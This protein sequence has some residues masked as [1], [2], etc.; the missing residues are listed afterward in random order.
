MDRVLASPG[1]PLDTATRGFMEQRFGHDFSQVRTHADSEGGESARRLNALAYTVGN[2]IAFAPGQY[3]PNTSGGR[4]LLAHELTH[5]VQQ[6]G[7][8]ELV[9]QRQPA[10]TVG[11][12]DTAVSVFAYAKGA[13]VGL[14]D[15]FPDALFGFAPNNISNWVHGVT[16]QNLTITEATADRVRAAFSGPVKQMIPGGGSGPDIPDVS[17]GIDRIGA[18]RFQI[19][20]DSGAK[21]LTSQE[22]RSAR[23]D[24]GATTLTPVAAKPRALPSADK[25]PANAPAPAPSNAPGAPLPGVEGPSKGDADKA[26]LDSLSKPSKTQDDLDKEDKDTVKKALKSAG[27]AFLKTAEGKRLTDA[28]SKEADKLP[29]VVLIAVPVALVAGALIGLGVTKQEL[30]I[31]ETPDIP[32]GKIG[33]VEMKFKVVY[34]GPVNKPTKASLTLTFAKGSLEVAPAFTATWRDPGKPPSNENASG[35]QGGLS[36]KIPL[37]KDADKKKEPTDTDKSRAELERLREED[38]RFRKGITFK[39]GTA[40]AKEAAL[41]KE[42][43]AKVV[44]D[45]F[46]KQFQPSSTPPPAGAWSTPRILDTL[47]VKPGPGKKLFNANQ[48]TKLIAAGFAASPGATVLVVGTYRGLAGTTAD[49][50]NASSEQESD[51]ASSANTVKGAIEQW[52]PAAKGRIETAVEIKGGARTFGLSAD[53]AAGLGARDVAVIFVPGS[54]AK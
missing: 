29:T 10:D 52:L 36:V 43:E 44:G 12:S 39:P 8:G 32:V 11:A 19:H 34:E 54:G 48:L 1:H 5:T 26:V 2:H 38:A 24:S 9:V 4:S 14:S 25:P 40:E 3:R 30:P 41:Q 6:A 46:R 37:G 49:E 51:A 18:G 7:G 50:L 45:S 23:S 20:I 35:F 21:R 42:A 17:I 53:D 22:V 16:D 47:D 13:V 15:I 31:T 27:D 33:G 28:A